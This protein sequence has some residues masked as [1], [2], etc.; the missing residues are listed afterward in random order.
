MKLYNYWRSGTSHRTRIALE[1]KGLDY[2][3]MPVNLVEREHK[4]ADY[5]AGNPQGMVPSLKL[6][7][8]TLLTQSVAILEY[9]EESF[10]DPR[11][12][13]EESRSRARVRAMAALIGCDIHP[14]NNLRVLT[15]VTGPLGG[16]AEARNAWI[17]HWIG[18]GFAALEQ[19]AGKDGYCFGSSPTLADCY[20][21][22]Q[23]YSARRF[24]IA[25]D[26]YPKLLAIDENC[27]RLEAF[28][29]AHPDRQPDSA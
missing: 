6:G 12:L 28:Q 2:D 19:L 9:L 26:A 22:P 29:R 23:I 27:H 20:L 5:L 24:G 17:A 8:G 21:I 13:P 1:L 14:L 15:Y 4:S 18:E 25:L 11:L 3:Y 10:P 16:D 7:D